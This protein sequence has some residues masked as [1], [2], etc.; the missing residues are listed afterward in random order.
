[1]NSIILILISVWYVYREIK[2]FLLTNDEL[3]VYANHNEDENE[4]VGNKYGRYEWVATVIQS[5]MVDRMNADLRKGK[6]LNFLDSRK[7]I[8]END[9]R[10]KWLIQLYYF[11]YEVK[12][13]AY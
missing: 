7:R 12:Q 4:Y 11:I 2:N 5:A 6:I 8:G 1:M 10:N 3:Y 13:N 9:S